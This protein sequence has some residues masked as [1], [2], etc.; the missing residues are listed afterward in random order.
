MIAKYIANGEFGLE[1]E[2][3]RVDEKG[4]LSH[5]K[6]PFQNNPSIERDFCEN[7]TEI[8]TGV[9]NNVDEVYSQLESLHEAVVKKIYSLESGKEYLWPF[10]NPPYVKNEE[11]IPIATFAEELKEKEIY[12]NYLSEK[13]GKKKM[14]FSGIHLN[15]SFSDECLKHLFELSG[16]TSFRVFKDNLYL[17]LAK[18]V[19]K[20]SWLIVYL[21]AASPL[22]DGSFLKDEDIG[23]DILSKYASARCSEIG[24]WNEFIPVLSYETL[25]EYVSSI[26]SY[27]DAGKLYSSA[28]LYHPVRLKPR[29][30]H[31]LENLRESGV[32]HIELRMLDLNPLSPIGIIKEDLYFIHL[33]ITYLM[34][35]DD[36]SFDG[37]EQIMAIN[38]V[39]KAALY[40]EKQ[41]LLDIGIGQ[42]KNIVVEAK[43]ILENIEKFYENSTLVYAKDVVSYQKRKLLN[44]EERYAV[45]IRNIFCDK[46][47]E[48][49]MSQAKKYAEGIVNR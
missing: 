8:I 16:E 49:G 43:K 20:Y 41:I 23:K 32:N 31:S 28:E 29:G 27:V 5:T 14:L 34:H 4:F 30:A 47:V 2:T 6:H 11:D 37:D 3:L 15:F 13:Y 10:S 46:Y 25:D 21:T 33:L 44:P 45:K 19:T 39:K 1:K 36:I 26:Q 35:L 38:N 40:D 7:Q 12:R 48:K 9:G 22:M 42:K 24:Y 18:K 17:Q